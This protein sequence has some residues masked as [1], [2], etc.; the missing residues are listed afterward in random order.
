[1]DLLFLFFTGVSI[2]LSGAMIPGPLTIFTISAALKTNKFAGLKIIFGHIILEFFFIAGILLGLQRFLSSSEFILTTTIIGSFSLVIMGILLILNAGRL[3]LSTL[4]S[5]SGFSKSLVMGGFFFSI[6]SPGFLIWWATIGLST[7][8]K[9][10]L[11]GATGVIIL[12]AGH[13]LADVSWYTFLSLTINKG[14]AYLTDKSYQ[15]LMRFFAVL[16]ILLGIRF[17]IMR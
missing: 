15:N 4:K 8:I 11:F 2:G 14:K 17:Y 3:K 9:S 7:L 13:W 16:L 10:L 5:D 6:I 12:T 1:M